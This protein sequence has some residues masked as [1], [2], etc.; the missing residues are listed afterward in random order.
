MHIDVL[1]LCRKFELIPKFFLSYELLKTRQFFKKGKGYMYNSPCFFPK[2]DSETY[3]GV[4]TCMYVSSMRI[5][6]ID[7]MLHV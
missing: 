1:M 3:I 7:I 6:D 5:E 4:L 2:M